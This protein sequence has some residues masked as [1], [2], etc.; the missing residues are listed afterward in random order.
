LPST[1]IQLGAAAVVASQWPV[2]DAAAAV[3][4]VSFYH[5]YGNGVPPATAFAQAQR[6]LRTA[7]RSEISTLLRNHASNVT[8]LGQLIADLP[9]VRIPFARAQDWAAF[10]YTGC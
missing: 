3:L 4:A 7:S 6:W 2:S 9:L 1:L 8:E 10:I 5:A